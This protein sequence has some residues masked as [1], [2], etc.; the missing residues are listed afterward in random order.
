ML[1]LCRQHEMVRIKGVEVCR[2]DNAFA[3]LHA[4]LLARTLVCMTVP[5]GSPS[6]GGNFK[7]NFK[8]TN[9]PSLPTPFYFFLVSISVFMAFSTV[10]H[11]TNSLDDCF[12][13]VLLVLSL[14]FWSF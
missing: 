2:H 12:I 5:T 8:D 10:F 6:R 13:T 4:S 11:S 9:Q 3:C 14:P 7:V 1:L